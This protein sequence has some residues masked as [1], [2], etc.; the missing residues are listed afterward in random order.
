VTGRFCLACGARLMLAVEEGRRR[1]RCPRCRWTF[2]NNP[3]PA[4][5]AVIIEGGRLLLGRRARPPYAR[6]WDLPGGFL[7][8]HELPLDAL[9]REL[10]EEI[11]VGVRR[12]A[13]I[14]FATD[15]YG[16]GGVTVLSAV[17]RVHPTSRRVRAD[18]DVSELHWFPLDRIPYRHLAFPSIRRV[19]R[20]Y[21]SR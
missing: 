11:G 1:R 6:A 2:Y 17:Y 5:A 12:A 7:E 18:D 21:L 10:R 8:T 3:V 9:R 15:P 4:T 13:L 14:G 16:P 19:L 20:R